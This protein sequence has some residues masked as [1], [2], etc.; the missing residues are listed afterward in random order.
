MRLWSS[1]EIADE[2]F[3]VHGNA[4]CEARGEDAS[5]TCFQHMLTQLTGSS[6][7]EVLY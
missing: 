2:N 4:K 3:G 5:A 7:F 1:L 6:N